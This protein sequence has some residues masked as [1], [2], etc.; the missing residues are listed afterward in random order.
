[1]SSPVPSQARTLQKL[2]LALFLRGRSSRGLQKDKAPQSIGRKLWGTLAL[3]A[4]VGLIALT[5]AGQGT[6]ALS[7]YLHAM[8]LVFLGM[9]IAAS[10]GEILFN[11]D[12]AEILLHRPVDS[13]TLLWAKVAVLVRVSLWI[14]CA[15]NLA[16]MVAGSLSDKGSPFFAPVH[17]ISICL[18]ALFCSGSVVLLYQ[19]CLRWFGRERLDNLMTTAQV[20][21]AVL[22]VVGS[23]MVPHLMIGMQGK[24]DPLA[25]QTWLFL[26]PPAWFASLDQVLLGGG[27]PAAWIMAGTGVLATAL[28]LGLAFGRMARVYEEGLQTLAES[29][30]RKERRPGKKRFL[31]LLTDAPPLRWMLREPVTRAAFRLVAAYLA[32]DRDMKLRL[33]PGLAPMMV[34]PMVFMVQ[35][36]RDKDGIN[37]GVAIAA[38]YLGMIP[39]TAMTML[40]FSQHWQAADLYRQ[41]PV[42]G[43][44]PFIHGA[45]RA[46][47][48]FLAVPAMALLVVITCFLP[49]GPSQLVTLLPGIIALPFFA[50]LPGALE[51]AAPLSKPVEEA[52]SAS[53][54]GFMF[55]AVFLAP[56]IPALGLGARHFGMLSLFLLLEAAL[57]AVGCWF[58]SRAIDRKAWDPLE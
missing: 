46:V 17:F 34:M 35:S 12:E 23:Q 58:L 27:K 39:L 16:G 45:V 51:K 2:Y 9:F 11:K 8:S 20:L 37:W 42:Q 29:R 52:K 33:Y 4:A 32:R 30:P 53:R 25:N 15:F 55:L 14:T 40:Q 13:R 10:A 48:I 57:I 41:A 5:F 22:M 24:M 7:I 6:F 3:Y 56:L 21:L 19:L 44:G 1:M 47:C 18:S 26:L 43:P 38:G 28:V 36:L 50:L 31:D 54:G 49:H